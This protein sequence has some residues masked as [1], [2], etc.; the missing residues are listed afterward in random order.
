MAWTTP[1]TQPTGTMITSTHYK[2][3][4]IDNIKFLHGPPTARVRA[5]TNAGL[6]SGAWTS[7]NFNTE[8]WDNNS[9]FSSTSNRKLICRTAGKYLVEFSAG[10]NASSAGQLRGIAIQKNTTT[11]GSGHEVKSL[12]NSTAVG[13]TGMVFSCSQLIALST[14]QF[15]RGEMIHDTGAA[16]E[17]STSA[18]TQPTLSM[19]WM[20]S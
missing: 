8:D 4:I 17:W 20:S 7:V 3:H 18:G 19:I 9:I 16:T 2:A 14:G 10:F 13:N 5:T 11:A 1:S 15:I 12:F 6:T